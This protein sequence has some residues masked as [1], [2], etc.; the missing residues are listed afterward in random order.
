MKN[1]FVFMAALGLFM[2]GWSANENIY[3]VGHRAFTDPLKLF[4]GPTMDAGLYQFVQ[5][6]PDGSIW[7]GVET[8]KRPLS[9]PVADGYGAYPLRLWGSNVLIEAGGQAVFPEV[10][11]NKIT[12]QEPVSHGEGGLT[13]DTS[14]LGSYIAVDA[15][16]CVLVYAND[17][18]KARWC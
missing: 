5:E 2:A 13:W 11:T 16:G 18:E 4:M 14:H 17:I 6:K 10:V 12:L 8:F 1:F 15:N 9:G 3:M 7:A